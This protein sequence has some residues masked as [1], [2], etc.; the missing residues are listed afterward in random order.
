MARRHYFARSAFCQPPISAFPAGFTGPAGSVSRETVRKPF[1]ADTGKAHV[2]QRAVW[3]QVA[4]GRAADANLEGRVRAEDP[5]MVGRSDATPAA[6]GTGGP[7]RRSRRARVTG[8]RRR[9]GWRRSS[10]G[11]FA[12]GGGRAACSGVRGGSGSAAV[13]GRAVRFTVRGGWQRGGAA[14]GRR[15]L[16]ARRCGSLSAAVGGQAVRFAVCGVQRREG[17]A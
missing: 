9:V 11:G 7:G 14:W 16:A 12:F 15:R 3:F 4:H 6:S 8:P 1:E 2:L 5:G 13:G 17:A 10:A